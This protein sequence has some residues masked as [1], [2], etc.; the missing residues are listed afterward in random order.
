MINDWIHRVKWLWQ[1]DDATLRDPDSETSEMAWMRLFGERLPPKKIYQ[2]QVYNLN[3]YWLDIYDGG[4]SDYLIDVNGQVF[5]SSYPGNNMIGILQG[6][7]VLIAQ[8]I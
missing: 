8:K 1:E 2:N 4:D 3:S 5:C 7:G 6:P